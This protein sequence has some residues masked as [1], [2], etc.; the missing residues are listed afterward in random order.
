MMRENDKQRREEERTILANNRDAI[1]QRASKYKSENKSKK[2]SNTRL[3]NAVVGAVLSIIGVTS[4]SGAIKNLIGSDEIKGIQDIQIEEAYNQTPEQ[5]VV[6]YLYTKLY[7]EL[8]ERNSVDELER[9]RVIRYKKDREEE[10]QQ[11]ENKNIPFIK[12]DA[13]I[14]PAEAIEG[15]DDATNFEK[16]YK[17]VEYNNK[18]L[19]ILKEN[20][21]EYV[22]CNVNVES[23]R[24]RNFPD[25]VSDTNPKNAKDGN[26]YVFMDS[27][28]IGENNFKKAILIDKKGRI[29]Y[30]YVADQYGYIEEKKDGGC[31]GMTNTHTYI[32]SNPSLPEYDESKIA[33]EVKN[34]DVINILSD[35]DM[36][37]YECQI[38]GDDNI[39][40]IRKNTVITESEFDYEGF[41]K[42]DTKIYGYADDGSLIT[43]KDN[44]GKD[45]EVLEDDT[46]EIDINTSKDGLYAVWDKDKHTVGYMYGNELYDMSSGEIISQMLDIREINEKNIENALKLEQ[47]NES[48][49]N[50]SDDKPCIVLDFKAITK[51]ELQNVITYCKESNINLGGVVFSIGSTNSPAGSLRLNMPHMADKSGSK[52][53]PIQRAWDQMEN[54]S[55]LNITG[56]T[57][58]RVNIEELR[59]NIEMLIDNDIA[60]G[61]YYYSAPINE[62]E[63]SCEAAY[64]YTVINYLNESSEKYR[65][66]T[67]KLPVSIDIE[68]GL[69][70]ASSYNL[71]RENS[72]NKR[73]A[74][75][76][77]KLVELLGDGIKEED[78][79]GKYFCIDN[80]NAKNGYNVISE[81]GVILYGDMRVGG[82]KLIDINNNP[83]GKVTGY[84]E[85]VEN[86]EQNYTVYQWMSCQ[87][88]YSVNN[89]YSDLENKFSALEKTKESMVDDES[90]YNDADVVQ[91]VLDGRICG[92]GCDY[93]ITSEQI[94]NKMIVGAQSKE[95]FR[96]IMK[97]AIKNEKVQD[98]EQ[99]R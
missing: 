37:C 87:I 89:D 35:E 1:I 53:M 20:I 82:G 16:I 60:V 62:T 66:Y 31:L 69:T 84:Y 73:R 3:I 8:P 9:N 63:V 38:E 5:A 64:I 98:N 46:L 30:G 24:F 17:T 80:K 34:G 71:S 13:V 78:E 12:V 2:I 26:L 49:V 39:Y 94:L 96:D 55:K 99:E 72:N 68:N 51:S 79:Q 61:M 90:L 15:K 21:D 11:D 33:G 22:E 23:L 32:R 77:Q 92:Y 52:D 95:N 28:G 29:D 50:S 18:D 85:M 93:S 88:I 81:K 70:D 74:E 25:T 56:T 58:G 75:L 4:N 57:T 36:F 47:Y 27:E 76:T 67:K 86:L 83:E 48:I 44:K 40:Y 10:W 14:A 45:V 7:S 43:R 97:N 65:N 59:E 91:F 42:F 19:Y 54:L 6:K 41:P